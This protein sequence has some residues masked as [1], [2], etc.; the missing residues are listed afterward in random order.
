MY[1]VLPTKGWQRNNSIDL[2][3]K[4]GLK[5]PIDLPSWRANW[6]ELSAYSKY[7]VGNQK[8]HPHH[9][10]HLEEFLRQMRRTQKTK[11]A[12]PIQVALLKL[13]CLVI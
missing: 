6:D 10:Y 9:E 8:V 11:G 1:I 13:V 4:W 12:F 2:E 7:P 3:A 5:Y